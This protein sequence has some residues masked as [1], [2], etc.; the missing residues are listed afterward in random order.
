[1]RGARGGGELRT[2]SLGFGFRVEGAR[3]WDGYGVVVCVKRGVKEG[4]T[5]DCDCNCSVGVR[6]AK[7]ANED[8]ETEREQTKLRGS[9]PLT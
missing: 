9:L 1:M 4:L 6:K 5:Q 2:S 7:G 3:V 8:S